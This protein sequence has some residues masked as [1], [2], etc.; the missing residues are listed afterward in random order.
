MTDAHARFRGRW[1]LPRNF[2]KRNG[3][4]LHRGHPIGRSELD[5][6]EY[7]GFFVSFQFS[8]MRLPP[9][10]IV[11]G[12]TTGWRTLGGNPRYEDGESKEEEGIETKVLD[13]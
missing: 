5:V 8:F 3:L 7:F 4:G 2:L 1:R 9:S 11:P 10:A 6:G 13:Q 12:G